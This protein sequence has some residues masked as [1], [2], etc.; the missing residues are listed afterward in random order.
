MKSNEDTLIRRDQEMM[1]RIQNRDKKIDM[2]KE[3]AQE[4]IEKYVVSPF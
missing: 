3:K 2:I 4:S 1:Q